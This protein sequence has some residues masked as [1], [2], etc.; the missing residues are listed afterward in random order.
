MPIISL[1]PT[2]ELMQ[3]DGLFRFLD[4]AKQVGAGMIVV[5]DPIPSG[6]NAAKEVS[7]PRAK[8][9]FEHLAAEEQNHYTLLK[10][11]FD[12]MS[13]PEGFAE[14]DGNPMLDGG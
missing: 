13:D 4:F 11:T 3:H 14:F 8:G 2:P 7:S 5:L 12:Y 9:I 1:V 6:A 10:N